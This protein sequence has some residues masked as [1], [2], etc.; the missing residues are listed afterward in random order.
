MQVKCSVLT[1]VLSSQQWFS[2]QSSLF[3]RLS[4]FGHCCSSR[5]L[6]MHGEITFQKNLAFR[7]NYSFVHKHYNLVSDFYQTEQWTPIC[8]HFY[9]RTCPPEFQTFLMILLKLYIYSLKIWG[10]LNYKLSSLESC[11]NKIEKKE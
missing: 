4:Y 6:S 2:W 11:D 8:L 3:L 5:F 7:L 1:F 10:F 9:S